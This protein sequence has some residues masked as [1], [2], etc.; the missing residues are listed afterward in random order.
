MKDSSEEQIDL[1]WQEMN[2]TPKMQI[3][4]VCDL[5]PSMKEFPYAVSAG[6]G[7]FLAEKMKGFF[8]NMYICAK[9]NP[10]IHL[11]EGT[12]FERLSNITDEWGSDFSIYKICDYFIDN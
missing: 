8:H 3:L 7:T 5:S 6:V 11:L 9:M 1:F 4:P 10:S 2:Y 12:P